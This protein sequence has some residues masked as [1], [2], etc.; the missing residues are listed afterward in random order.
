MSPR[1]A[2]R[3]TLGLLLLALLLPVGSSAEV[4]RF[5]L[6]AFRADTLDGCSPGQVPLETVA[7]I[8]LWRYDREVT[9][10]R[11]RPPVAPPGA[12]ETMLVLPGLEQVTYGITTRAPGGRSSCMSNLVTFNGR[13][14]TDPPAP[15]AGAWLGSPR[16]NPARGLVA[17]PLGLTEPGEVSLDV[18]D[19]AGRLVARL[20]HAPW[21]AGVHI[22]LWDA[23]RAAPGVYLVRVRA[24][25]WQAAV[26]V[27]VLR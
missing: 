26:R 21:S 16:P 27:L 24:R 8:E 18:L 13:A 23:T 3:A 11:S 19:I 12:E 2:L 4:L 10:E 5:R 22:L 9:L 20:T 15:A 7:L 1:S 25:G 6:P 17:I 14:G